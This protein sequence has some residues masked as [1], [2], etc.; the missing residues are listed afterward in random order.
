MRVPILY[1]LPYYIHHLNYIKFITDHFTIHYGTKQ[2]L[3]L[4]K[5]SSFRNLKKKKVF[6]VPPMSYWSKDNHPNKAF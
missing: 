5:K 4:E 3:G 6:V 1:S 2:Y